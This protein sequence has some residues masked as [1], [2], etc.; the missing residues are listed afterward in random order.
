MKYKEIIPV[1]NEILSQYSFALTIRQIYYRLISD[2]YNLFSNTRSMYNSLDRMLVRAREV[3]EIDGK[4]IEDRT[5]QTIGGDQGWEDPDSYL[6]KV[7]EYI[8]SCWEKYSKEVWASQQFKL[9]VWIEKDAL[10]SVISETTHP[11]RV[12][13]FPSRGYSSY[14]KIKEA[15]DRLKYYRDKQIIILHLADHDP[16][17]FDMTK[18]LINRFEK[19]GDDSIEIKRIGLNYDQVEK[20]NLRPNPVKTADPR[21][22]SYISHYGEECWELD[23]LPPNELQSIVE[24][25]IKNYIDQKAWDAKLE[26]IEEEREEIRE[27]IDEIT[28]GF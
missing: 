27:R 24:K 23:A 20:F 16:S 28:K 5:R 18:D 2:P 6:D 1:V 17:G 26:E 14:T 11:F 7:L 25:E 22:L 8:K 9:E 12:L 3:G 15:L 13:V 10:A 4:R 19:Y 21:A